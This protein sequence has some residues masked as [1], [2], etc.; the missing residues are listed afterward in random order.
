[1]RLCESKVWRQRPVIE[2][3]WSRRWK[4]QKCRE[5]GCATAGAVGSKQP[6]YPVRC[7]QGLGQEAPGTASGPVGS[8]GSVP[9]AAA[10]TLLHVCSVVR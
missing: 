1:M 2:H 5:H 10:Y 9:D 4:A 8:V 6:V 3:F 7:A